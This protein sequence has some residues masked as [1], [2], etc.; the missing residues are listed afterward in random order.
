MAGPI[1]G[2]L[3][4][5]SG[6]AD[7][8]SG[9]AGSP[10]QA[11]ASLGS[12]YANAYNASLRMNEANYGNILKGYQDSL[13]QLQDSQ[14]AITQGYGG[15]TQQVMGNLNNIEASQKQAILDQYAQA[16]GHAT[17]SLT[18]RGLGNTTVADSVRRGLEYD[19]AKAETGLANQMAGLRAGYQQNLGMA[20]L[21]YRN[22]AAMQN[23]GLAQAQ[24][25]W[26]NSV[27]AGYPNA[28]LYG[29]LA[30]QFGQ[31]QQA[32]ADRD[33]MKAQAA[34]MPGAGS[35]GGGGLTLGGG[36]GFFNQTQPV[37]GSTPALQGV[38]GGPNPYARLTSQYIPGYTGGGIDTMNRAAEMNYGL[39]ALGGAYA[40][41]QDAASQGPQPQNSTDFGALLGGA[42]G[43]MAASP[44]GG[45]PD[46]NS[47]D[48]Y[49]F[50][51]DDYTS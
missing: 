43:Y 26:M 44:Y 5:L 27:N 49:G 37:P 30:S 35:V 19:R 3:P 8:F 17:Q 2:Q 24:L 34:R 40:G 45:T 25:Q 12:N 31:T 29:Q 39:G 14:N 21:A 11:M 38:G 9:L 1:Q 46:Y 4:W 18:S 51:A 41:Y 32:N 13:Q 16:G 15:L 50:Y 7:Y 42:G 36:R 20:D 48:D 33:L 22:Q 6:G 23:A 10:Q 47:Q 28:G